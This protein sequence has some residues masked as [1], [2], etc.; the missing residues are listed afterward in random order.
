MKKPLFMKRFFHWVYRVTESTETWGSPK[1]LLQ[2]VLDWGLIGMAFR[3][4]PEASF[5]DHSRMSFLGFRD[6]FLAVIEIAD[7]DFFCLT[8]LKSARF[9]VDDVPSLCVGV[10][11]EKVIHIRTP[12]FTARTLFGWRNQRKA[13]DRLRRRQR[14]RDQPSVQI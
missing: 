10:L 13:G 6:G 7:E 1:D 8:R 3:A 5:K 9:H 12:F 4:A 11:G 14:L 2:F